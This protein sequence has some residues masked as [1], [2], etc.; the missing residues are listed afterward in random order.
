MDCPEH[1]ISDNGPQFVSTEFES[2]LKMNGVRHTCSAPYYP[3][4]NGEAECFVQTLKQFLRADKY[5]RCGVQTKVSRFLSYRST[6]N[7]TTGRTPSEL[8]LKW[9]IITRLDLLKPNVS[10]VITHSQ[11][12]QK[13]HYD[14]QTK[15]RTFEVGE[16]V[17]VQN[18][19]GASK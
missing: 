4:T 10:E 17:L 5:D 12:Q 9:Q 8:F 15:H 6:L 11:S 7:S 18:F 13:Y 19:R 2:F 14:K 16:H 1:L 3:Q